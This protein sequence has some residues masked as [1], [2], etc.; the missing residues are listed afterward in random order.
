MVTGGSGF[1]ASHLV[2]RLV[3]LG[4]FVVNLDKF[5]Y[6]SFDN[7][8]SIERKYKYIQGNICNR[9]LVWY[10]F[11][12]YNINVIFHLAAQTH[13]DNSFYNSTQFTM[14]NIVGTHNLLECMR[15]FNQWHK[16][17]NGNSNGNS[18]GNDKG[19]GNNNRKG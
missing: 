14:D 2:D 8:R 9:E 15:E 4:H 5:D 6:C 1:I 10:I 16:K 12:E 3:T 7:T 13:V 18:N 19:N 17:V 11:N